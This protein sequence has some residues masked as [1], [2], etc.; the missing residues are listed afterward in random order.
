MD[1]IESEYRCSYATV[2][3]SNDVELAQQ[4]SQMTMYDVKT[5]Y[6]QAK[7]AVLN[8]SE[9]EAKVREATN[10]DPW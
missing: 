2:Q 9:T 5:Y 7:N 6:N 4:A 3:L 10:D 8:V 1:Y